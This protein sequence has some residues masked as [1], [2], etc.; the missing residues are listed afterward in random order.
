LLQ[1]V[2]E[3]DEADRGCVKLGDKKEFSPTE[4]SGPTLLLLLPKP[5]S[6]VRSLVH[7]I[8][9]NHAFAGVKGTDE[10]GIVRFCDMMNLH[11][12][13]SAR[14]RAGPLHAGNL[15]RDVYE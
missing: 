13:V 5:S 2:V 10:P 9:W 14:C 11:L 15:L 3:I 12:G 7:F 1:V 8:R 6:N 4:R